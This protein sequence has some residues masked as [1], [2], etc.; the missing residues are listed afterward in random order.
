MANAFG[1]FV[2]SILNWASA[3]DHRYR[4]ACKMMELD[5][6]ILEDVGITREELMEEL[7]IGPGK[8]HERQATGQETGLWGGFASSR[9]ARGSS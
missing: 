6:K 5:E 2:H 8:G 7:G 1:N 9:V 3:A 4:E